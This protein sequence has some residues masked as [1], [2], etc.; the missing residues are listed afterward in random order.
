M[1]ES[2]YRIACYKSQIDLCLR[3]ALLANVFFLN[4]TDISLAIITF[5]QIFCIDMFH[6]NIFNRVTFMEILY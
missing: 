2:L 5:F 6:I 1:I 3:D 4:F